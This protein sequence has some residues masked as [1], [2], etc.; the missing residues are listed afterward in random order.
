MSNDIKLL[1]EKIELIEGESV[2]VTKVVKSLLSQGY[3]KPKDILTLIKNDYPNLD[4]KVLKT[5]LKNPQ[6]ASR[7]GPTTTQAIMQFI[8]SMSSRHPG[9]TA[10]AIIMGLFAAWEAGVSLRDAVDWASEKIKNAF[11]SASDSVSNS[12]DSVQ[13]SI[14]KPDMQSPSGNISN[15]STKTYKDQLTSDEIDTL[16]ADMQKLAS[17]P[18]AQ[19]NPTI[20]KILAKYNETY[21]K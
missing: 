13:N 18:D 3:S 8:T 1:I 20:Q 21:K 10:A 7:L 15:L 9:I 2:E 11:N 6:I 16:A 19:S 4:I 5:V 14:S 12:I 17:R